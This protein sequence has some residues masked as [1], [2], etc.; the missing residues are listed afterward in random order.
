MWVEPRLN[1]SLRCRVW[2]GKGR[3]TGTGTGTGTGQAVDQAVDEKRTRIKTSSYRVGHAA[4]QGISLA[5]LGVAW[6]QST[7]KAVG[8]WEEGCIE[9]ELM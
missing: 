9:I 4:R 1:G 3:G 6:Q 2:A 8:E 5:S 7:G